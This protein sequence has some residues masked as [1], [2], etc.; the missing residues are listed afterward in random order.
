MVRVVV[1]ID[2]PVTSGPDADEC[3]IIVAGLGA[4]GHGYV[5]YDASEGGLSPNEWATVAVH[6]YHTRAADRIVA[7][8]NQGGEMV[9]TVIRSVD[10]R[11]SY[12]GVHASKGKVTRAE[13]IAALYE[14]RK[15]HHVGL[16][17]KLEDQM[18]KFKQ[19]TDKRNAKSPD[20]VDALVWA[21]WELMINEETRSSIRV[22]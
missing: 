21:L 20:R 8:V 5:L 11:V 15:V 13:P 9:E 14:Q 1:A 16:H 6:Q 10:N 19:G 17:G 18:C 7:E 12:K 22:L 2:P 4:D 3:G